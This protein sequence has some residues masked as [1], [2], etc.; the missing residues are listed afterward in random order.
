MP[1]K[2]NQT[3]AAKSAVPPVPAAR[4]A[5]KPVV[6]KPA[7]KTPI[8]K[9]VQSDVVY[10]IDDDSREISRKKGDSAP[11]VLAT[12]TPAGG[13][14]YVSA[15]T[16]KMHPQVVRF[17][18]DEK[19]EFNPDGVTVDDSELE[20]K[21]T[22]IDDEHTEE[23]NASIPSPPKKTIESGDKTP[24]YVDWLRKHKP[25]TYAQKYGIVGEGQVT[26]YLPAQDE[27]GRP[28]LKAVTSEA[29]LARRKTHR[30]EKLEAGDPADDSG[31]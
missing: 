10:S 4:A 20:S 27:R 17:L 14:H 19:I 23:Y 30:T 29:I 16:R 25:K 21:D 6:V 18:T 8:K 24:A 2:L 28:T 15:E 12:L 9:K 22:D 13:I 31:E 7:A 3:P 26:K 1:P 5:A 11:V